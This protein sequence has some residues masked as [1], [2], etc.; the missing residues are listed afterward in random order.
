MRR[1]FVR[2]DRWLPLRLVADETYVLEVPY[3]VTR[4]E[5]G[6]IKEAW[7]AAGGYNAIVVSGGITI[8]RTRKPL[9]YR[10]RHAR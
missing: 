9:R 7:R 2:R 6:R 5:T 10:P 1:P 8:A 3:H 4:E